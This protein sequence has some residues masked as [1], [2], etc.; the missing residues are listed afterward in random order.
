MKKPLVSVVTP[1][2]NGEKYLE[3][4]IESVLNQDYDNLEFIIIDDCSPDST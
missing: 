2:Y 4:C 1:V 3:E